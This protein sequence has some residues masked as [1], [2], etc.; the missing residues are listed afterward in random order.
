MWLPLTDRIL[1]GVDLWSESSFG[2]ED[3]HPIIA[4]KGEVISWHGSSRKHYVNPNAS[5]NTRVSID[6]RI[7]VEG[8]FDPLWEMQG[9]TDDHSRK[10]VEL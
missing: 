5:I 7:G 3:Y 4:N 2:E 8:Y 1:T 9:T 10:K 6:F